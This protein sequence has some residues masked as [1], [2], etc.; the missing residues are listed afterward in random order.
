MPGI[1]S[2]DYVSIFLFISFIGNTPQHRSIDIFFFVIYYEAQSFLYTGSY[3]KLSFSS[4]NVY[5]CRINTDDVS[6]QLFLYFK[7]FY[8]S[9]ID[10]TDIMEYIIQY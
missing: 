9:V 2:I 4:L 10:I 6:I 8:N 7:L 3:T 1:L 5:Y